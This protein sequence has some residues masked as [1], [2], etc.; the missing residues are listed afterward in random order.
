MFQDNLGVRFKRVSGER[1]QVVFT[2][3]NSRAVDV[4]ANF[5]VKI[6]GENRSYEVTSCDPPVP[7]LEALVSKLNETNDF[8]SFVIIMRR[9]FKDLV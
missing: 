4:N 6:A 3:L 5:I 7:D 2:C 9:R 1:L 8:K